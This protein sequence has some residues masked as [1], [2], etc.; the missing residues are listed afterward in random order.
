MR[1]LRRP[2]SRYK[3]DFMHVKPPYLSLVWMC[4]TLI[5]IFSYMIGLSY[6]FTMIGEHRLEWHAYI[7]SGLALSGLFNGLRQW[8]L[9]KNRLKKIAIWIPIY[10]IWLP[11]G[12]II[13][14][15]SLMLIDASYQS[16]AT[17]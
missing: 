5:T 15:F 11:L 10:I 2:I 3:E 4:W 6:S 7:L 1:L 12:L 13:S 16:I 14:Y 17:S 9:L 8:V